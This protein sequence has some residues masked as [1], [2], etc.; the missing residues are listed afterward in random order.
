M[1]ILVF[2][3][4]DLA[5]PHAGGA[6]VYL[7]EVTRRWA[8]SGHRVA[9]FAAAVAGRPAGEVVD[10]VTVIRRGGRLGVY[11]AAHD[12]YE[13]GGCGPVDAVVDMVNTRPFGCASWAGEAP[14]VAFIHQL[15][16]EIW[17]HELPLPVALAGR[18]L[19]EPRW[20]AAYR[21][22]PVLTVS[23]SSR[24]SLVA[25]GLRD[26]TVVGEGVDRR[27]R[28]GVAR[29]DSPTVLFLGRLSASKR[30]LHA[31]AA[32]E[33]LRRQV[34]AAKLW[35]VGDGPQRERV[36]RRAGPGVRL[37]GRVDRDRR[38]ELLARAH[39]L[40][41]TS[42]REGWALVVDEAAA[43]GTPTIA[44]DRPG[45]RDSV[46]AAGGILVP[47]RPAALAAALAAHLPRLTAQPA[48][49][50]W[51]GGALDWDLVAAQVL[52]RIEERLGSTSDRRVV[53]PSNRR[54]AA[55]AT[56]PR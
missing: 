46:P 12:Y 50:G 51:A 19:L 9:I 53:A 5:H 26:V 36:L 23:E 52:R 30:P 17:F 28:P 31:L 16:R 38:D 7:H 47:P 56:V 43:M 42:V 11:R 37:H 54:G 22:R 25:A 29:E 15:C 21:E 44:Y 14:V 33:I 49:A 4:K 1:R 41:A 2:N 40:I 18:Y 39:V 10:G 13:G 55:A 3:W 45:L 34:P 20:L 48:T 32:F 8:A 35:F 27:P 24:A 6:E